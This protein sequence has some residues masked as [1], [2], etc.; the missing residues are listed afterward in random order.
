MRSSTNAKRNYESPPVSPVLVSQANCLPV[1]GVPPKRWPDLVR[2]RGIPYRRVGQLVVVSLEVAVSAL[3][4]EDSPTA[5]GTSD[6][7]A[8]CR[9]ALGLRRRGER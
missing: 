9:A 3:S 2:A 8:A 5:T 7:A 6:P 4:P 1:L